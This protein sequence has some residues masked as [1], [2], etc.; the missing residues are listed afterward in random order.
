MNENTNL[1]PR[2]IV[3]YLDQYIIGQSDA[4]RSVAVALRN[5]WRAS[6]LTPEMAKEVSPKNILLI[7]PTGVGKTEIARRIATLT[8]APFV[9]VEA[10]KYTEVGYVGRD[11]ES[12]IRDLAEEAV[13]LVKKEESARHGK[14]ADEEAIHRIAEA[15]WPSKKVETRSPMDIIFGET[16]KETPMDEGEKERRK[17]LETRIR[18]GDLDDRV[19]EIEVEEKGNPGNTDNEQANQISMMLSSM[20]PKKMKKKKVTVRD[21]KRIL[22]EAAADE[23][24]DMEVVKDKAI[25]YAEERGIIF[26]DEI[27][28]IAGGRSSGGPDVSREGVQRDILPIVEVSKPSDLIPEL[29]GRFPIRV[30]LSSLTKDDLRSILTEPRQALIRQYTALLETEG[31][32]I[33]F[34]EDALSAIADIASRVNTETED[35][36]ARR[37]YTILERVLE[38]L[39]FDAPDLEDKHVTIDERY[40]RNKLGD[41]TENI[42]ISNYIL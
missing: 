30:E 8:R 5:R 3:E 15:M 9:K 11:V 42:D 33:T 37:L 41:V 32:D 16:K 12:M 22:A 31:V 24:V 38:D 18:N 39:S 34:T 28:K 17:D 21:A 29:Q 26:I 13:R 40:V 35:I 14:D 19:I 25:H 36:G 7:G 20:M 27:D 4:K 6:R 23:M 1:T 10:T 2:K